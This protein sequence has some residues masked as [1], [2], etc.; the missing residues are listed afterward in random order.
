MLKIGENEYKIMKT[1][2]SINRQIVKR[3][4]GQKPTCRKPELK[5]RNKYSILSDQPNPEKKSV[6]IG[7]SIVRNQYTHYGTKNSKTTRRVECYGG[8]KIKSGIKLKEK[9]F[10][11]SI[12][13]IK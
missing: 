6:S 4:K 1:G 11:D 3:D 8:I 7:D 2:N 10:N 9:Q 13:W 5:F 12:S